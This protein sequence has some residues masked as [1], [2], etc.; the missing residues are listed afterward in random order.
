MKKK[1]IIIVLAISIFLRLAFSSPASA[2]ADVK[3]TMI[4]KAMLQGLVSCTGSG[5]NASL[6]KTIL[7]SDLDT[8]TGPE[9]LLSGG[10]DELYAMPS[11]HKTT[12]FDY[13]DRGKEDIYS[14]ESIFSGLD[15]KQGR[16]KSIFE[17]A[18]TGIFTKGSNISEKETWVKKVAHYKKETSTN[19]SSG[20]NG[21]SNCFR[22]ETYLWYYNTPSVTDRKTDMGAYNSPSQSFCLQLNGNGVVTGGSVSSNGDGSEWDKVFVDWLGVRGSAAPAPPRYENGRF[23]IPYKLDKNGRS[24]YQTI[25]PI[26]KTPSAVKKEIKSALVSLVNALA[27]L[28][29]K[30]E[31]GE[32]SAVFIACADPAADGRATAMCQHGSDYRKA[33]Y[34]VGLMNGGNNEVREHDEKNST[35][36]NKAVYT[37]TDDSWAIIKTVTGKDDNIEAEKAT[38]LTYDEKIMLYQVYLVQVLGA[39][40]SCKTE[41]NGAGDTIT[42]FNLGNTEADANCTVNYSGAS[43]ITLNGVR[44]RIIGDGRSSTT[45]TYYSYVIGG[46]S[47]KGIIDFLH[48]V[49]PNHK[50]SFPSITDST[51]YNSDM[52]N[53][54]DVQKTAE[55][56]N[57][58]KKT[59]YDSAGVSNWIACPI[60]DNG[61]SASTMLYGFIENM[62]QVN[63]KL[64]S[65]QDDASGTFGAWSS[66]RNIANVMFIIIFIIVIMSQI[67][68]VGIDNYG[69][70]KILPKLILGALLVNISFFICQ[71]C[72]DVANITG[73]GIKGLFNTMA[74]RM[75][76]NRNIAF[77]FGGSQGQSAAILGGSAVILAAIV[78]AAWYFS[79]G[80]I[81]VPILLG[82]I[83]AVIGFIF[84]LIMLAVRQGLAVMLV[85]ISPLAF[86]AYMLPNTKGLFSKWLKLFSG[87]LLAYPICSMVVYGGQMVSTIILLA[88][89]G[90]DAKVTNF[91]LALTSAIL[92]IVPVFFIPTMIIKSMSSISTF[93]NSVKARATTA[94]KGAFDRSYMAGNMRDVAGAKKDKRYAGIAQRKI[95]R[96][97]SKKNLSVGQRAQLRTAQNMKD[98]YLKKNAD[99]YS[100]MTKAMDKS[101]LK[102]MGLEA[103]SGDTKD[104]EKFDAAVAQLFATG[105]D[106][107]AFDLINAASAQTIG[108]NTEELEKFKTVVATRGGTIGKAY[109]KALGRNGPMSLAAAMSNG[110]LKDAFSGMGT[111][112]VAGMSKDE[113]DF[114]S[115]SPNARG[116]FSEK[117]LAAAVGT[118]TSGKAAQN[119]LRLIQNSGQG[120]KVKDALTLEQYAAADEN[121]L[122]NGLGFTDADHARYAQQIVESG[123]DQLIASVSDQAQR[124]AVE[125]ALLAAKTEREKFQT[126]SLAAQE[127]AATTL[128]SIN[129]GVG[130]CR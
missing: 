50:L 128:G 45:L 75:T 108:M 86:I 110:S 34:Y 11:N 123:N 76:N 71:A 99:L 33:K 66:F 9:S 64:F 4:Q 58:E 115:K 1:N 61:T 30:A 127:S 14:C 48:G 97:R 70:K 12:V 126:D 29:S 20:S 23:I 79:G 51:A 22:F 55:K 56:E 27:S 65:T 102:D 72:V 19:S 21:G 105:N 73:G 101:Q 112:A 42:W 109:A 28:E 120:S 67:T 119:L 3:E 94:G 92:S 35:Y 90:S 38:Y 85:V 98:S 80:G 113:L 96:L 114:M 40:V 26:G 121:I 49:S 122:K 46:L 74:G 124:D 13:L 41:G 7:G 81:L 91:A 78:G 39:E 60:I 95:D 125:A 24:E 69:I 57:E 83:G 118:H 6:K 2:A 54:D 107:E 68:G 10:K 36:S 52:N 17:R 111:N 44:E 18:G 129:T 103:L 16:I 116:M 117:Q 47:Y 84:L 130:G 93:A 104:M 59:C 31:L 87:T 15:I 37:A 63:T 89:A 100:G 53:P 25:D 62:L 43:D 5:P 8:M 106:A 88:A 82:V 32:N 77:A